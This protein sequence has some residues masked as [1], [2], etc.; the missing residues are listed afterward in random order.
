MPRTT[1]DIEGPVLKEIKALQKKVKLP[2]SRI[3]SRLLA[4]ALKSHESSRKPRPFR[5]TSRPMKA[6]VDL[7]DKEAVYAVLDRERE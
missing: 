3:V 4:E 6:L 5:W 7:E 1:I 2:M